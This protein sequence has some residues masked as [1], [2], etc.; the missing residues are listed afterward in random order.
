VNAYVSY[1]KQLTNLHEILYLESCIK[2]RQAIVFFRHSQ[3]IIFHETQ[4]K[5]LMVTKEFNSGLLAVVLLLLVVE[6]GAYIPSQKHGMLDTT[7]F[8]DSAPR[9][10]PEDSHR[11]IRRRENLKSHTE[12]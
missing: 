10:I 5:R 1:P 2:H 3:T 11:H 7:V 9:N 4:I 8:W 6:R 12:R